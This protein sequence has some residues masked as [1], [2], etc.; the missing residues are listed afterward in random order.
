MSSLAQWLGS[1]LAFHTSL[2]RILLHG[3]TVFSPHLFLRAYIDCQLELAGN[4]VPLMAMA[5]I[6]LDFKFSAVQYCTLAERQLFSHSSVSLQNPN[7]HSPFC[8]QPPGPYNC[9]NYGQWSFLSLLHR[10]SRLHCLSAS[11]RLGARTLHYV[12]FSETRF[13]LW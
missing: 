5:P 3:V 4:W 6:F 13:S 11:V 8:I 9:I 10:G 2:V 7:L 12:L 1:R